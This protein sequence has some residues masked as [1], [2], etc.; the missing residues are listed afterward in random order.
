MLTVPQLRAARALLGWSQLELAE[1]AKVS[2]PTIQRLENPKYG[3]QAS[4]L[5]IVTA[6][7]QALEVNGVL[8]LSSSE[9]AG[10]GVRLAVPSA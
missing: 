4:S 7:R 5:R 9:G 3:P 2:F 6:V 10:E 8:F 1:R